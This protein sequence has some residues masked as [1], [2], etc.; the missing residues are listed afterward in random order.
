MLLSL[1]RNDTACFY[2]QKWLIGGIA[3]KSIMTGFP[4]ARQCYFDCTTY[5]FLSLFQLGK[6]P[7]TTDGAKAVVKAITGAKDMKI[8]ELN[9]EVRHHLL[10]LIVQF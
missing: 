4:A 2:N 10:I 8:K 3:L 5:R 6:N 1:G 7:L 9:L